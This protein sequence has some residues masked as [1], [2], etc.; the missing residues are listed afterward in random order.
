MPELN[1]HTSPLPDETPAPDEVAQTPA[2]MERSVGR[3]FM[4]SPLY[5]VGGHDVDA[6]KGIIRNVA[7]ATVGQTKNKISFDQ[8][9][10]GSLVE[11][12]N[13]KRGGVKVRFG[14][15]NISNTALGTF[16]GRAKNFRATSGVARADL[17]LSGVAKETPQGDLWQYVT[18]MAAKEP[19][20]FGVSVVIDFD[21]YYMRN[22]D[23]EKQKL[24]GPGAGDQPFFGQVAK[25]HAA[26]MVDDPAANP[27][28][29]FSA[30]AMDSW[31]GQVTE[32]LDT[33]PEIFAYAEQHPDVMDAFMARYK[34][35]QERRASAE[36]KEA[37]MA[38]AKAAEKMETKPEVK[39]DAKAAEA[40][41]PKAETVQMEAPAKA[42]EPT[43]PAA[44]SA[45]P[46]PVESPDPRAEFKRMVETFGAEFA[47]QAYADGLTYEQALTKHYEKVKAENA[48][49]RTKLAAQK[50]GAAPASFSPVVEPT[51]ADQAKA[52]EAK[53]AQRLTLKVGPNLAKV[54]AGM[55]FRK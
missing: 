20:A 28:G 8:E 16:L 32:F 23:G 31:A 40:Q 21:S 44:E 47:A 29:L 5:G 14:H 15:P 52:A 3:W 7:I 51:P 37:V 2:A 39:V 1:E 46:P 26:D 27:D 17:F 50:S 54:A 19:D 11:L 30:W 4:S 22:A 43:P 42:A 53:E 13:A 49:L 41:T 45:E 48:E 12:G 25:F 24:D 38:D 34:A 9:T 55:K 36:R 35:Y 10:I 18:S 6:T 33:H